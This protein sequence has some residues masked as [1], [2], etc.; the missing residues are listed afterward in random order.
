MTNLDTL[1]Q[2]WRMRM[3]ARYI[4]RGAS[5]LDV[6]S[7]DG[8]LFDYLG[9]DR[10]NGGVGI[11]P[12]VPEDATSKA[13]ARLV[14]GSFPDD[15]PP[16]PPFDTVTML[17]VLEHVPMELQEVWAHAAAELLKPG[18]HLLITTPSPLVDPILDVL[19]RVRLIDGMAL[20]EH[21]GFEPASVP[22]TFCSAGLTLERHRRF[23]LGLNHLFVFTR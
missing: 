5:V 1:L 4:P 23:Q 15:L 18:G 11:D 10:V 12:T 13:G 22:S 14:R 20:E 2:R 16:L 8:A 17:A 19:T 21:Y 9:P 7:A 3:A 6:G